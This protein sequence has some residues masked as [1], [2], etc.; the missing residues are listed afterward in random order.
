MDREHED[1]RRKITGYGIPTEYRGIRFRSRT[2][3]RWAAFFDMLPWPWVY[4][5][6]D[7]SGYI[8]D[9]ILRFEH[10]DLLVEVKP[11]TS[12]EDPMMEDAKLKIDESGWGDE[13]LLLGAFP[14]DLDE[15]TAQPV[16]GLMRSQDRGV[17]I[18]DEA[19]A[20]W[21]LS[22]GRPS[23]LNAAGSWHCRQ[24]GAGDGNAHVGNVEPLA[25]LWAEAANRVQWRAGT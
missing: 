7:L 24:C 10:A 16:I 22:C 20:F 4:E 19:R 13:A 17:W 18:W 2:E 15:H 11:A 3:A 21:C 14:F 25:G 5:P 23:L 1:L 9:Y 12:A 8:P 6:I